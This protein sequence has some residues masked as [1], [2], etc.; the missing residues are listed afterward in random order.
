VVVIDEVVL[1]SDLLLGGIESD[2]VQVCNSF[3]SLIR[4]ELFKS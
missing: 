1:D 2:L 4:T 3:V